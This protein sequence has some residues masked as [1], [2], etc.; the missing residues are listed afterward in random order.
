MT[1]FVRKKPTTWVRA[2][3]LRA[4]FP[5]WPVKTPPYDGFSGLYRISCHASV[6]AGLGT[7]AI[8]LSFQYSTLCYNLDA[9]DL[10]RPRWGLLHLE[11]GFLVV[12]AIFHTAIHTKMLDNQ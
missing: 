7:R 3:A 8:Q 12:P 11:E 10:D 6:T 5:T 1:I 2:C 4:G 9:K